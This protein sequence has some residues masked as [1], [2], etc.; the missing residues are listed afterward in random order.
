MNDACQV[1]FD[2]KELLCCG[3][4]VVFGWIGPD[5]CQQ[6]RNGA[7]TSGWIMV[8]KEGWLPPAW[9]ELLTL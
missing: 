5:V 9:V 4:A 1:E 3:R 8:Q 7:K 2:D 6:K